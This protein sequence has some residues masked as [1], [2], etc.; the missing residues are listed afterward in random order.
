MGRR[1]KSED[2]FNG[3]SKAWL[4]LESRPGG[5]FVPHSASLARTEA[6]AKQD[7]LLLGCESRNPLICVR[8]DASVLV[9]YCPE[10]PVYFGSKE[11]T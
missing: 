3:V 10:I 7:M 2:L 1:G 4:F 8:V 5:T 9:E 6:V 11:K